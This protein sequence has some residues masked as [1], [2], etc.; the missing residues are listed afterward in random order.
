MRFAFIA[1]NKGM[2]PI[3]RMCQILGVSARG[4]RAFCA[5][6]SVPANA[7]I[8]WS[9]PTFGNNLRCLWAAMAGPE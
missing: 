5:R 9:W 7:R 3:D 8:W 4:Y 2:L 1:K 6:P